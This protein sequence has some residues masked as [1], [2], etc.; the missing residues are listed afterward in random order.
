MFITVN[1]QFIRLCCP[2]Q[3]N[4]TAAVAHLL[5]IFW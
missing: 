5:F 4:S 1:R 2:I 3:R